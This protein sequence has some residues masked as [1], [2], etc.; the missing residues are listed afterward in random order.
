MPAAA[1]GV[2]GAGGGRAWGYRRRHT[3]RAQVESGDT[4]THKSRAAGGTRVPVE[5]GME[6]CP[7]DLAGVGRVRARGSRAGHGFALPVSDPAV[8]IPKIM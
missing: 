2:L 8:A 1:H 5:H 6:F 4:T 7:I 3:T